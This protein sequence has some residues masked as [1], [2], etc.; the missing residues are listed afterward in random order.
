MVQG[1]SDNLSENMLQDRQAHPPTKTKVTFFNSVQETRV[2][3]RDKKKL[4]LRVTIITRVFS[5]T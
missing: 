1:F 5:C 3:K 4:Y 2:F